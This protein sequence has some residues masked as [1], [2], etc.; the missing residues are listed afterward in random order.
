M[1]HKENKK[2]ENLLVYDKAMWLFCKIFLNEDQIVNIKN[3]VIEMQEF[4]YIY[5][6]PDVDQRR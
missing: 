1:K 3:H 5:L 2:I 4:S 6:D